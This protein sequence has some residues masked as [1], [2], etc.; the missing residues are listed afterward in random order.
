MPLA[1]SLHVQVI[2]PWDVKGGSDGKID[3]DKLSRDVSHWTPS[4]SASV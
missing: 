2:T 4:L 1:A 3:Y